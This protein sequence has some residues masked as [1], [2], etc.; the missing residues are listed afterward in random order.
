MP[1]AEELPTE[2]C[3]G[4]KCGQPVVMATDDRSLRRIAVNPDPH[5]AGKVKLFKRLD[6]RGNVR[7]GAH[8][9]TPTE[10]ATTSWGS[11]LHQL[12]S[13][14]CP[15]ASRPQRKSRTS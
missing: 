5:P 1:S 15:A 14:T 12:H 4:H 11:V 6:V 7:V 2:A 8:T 3:P 13:A 10:L 9:C